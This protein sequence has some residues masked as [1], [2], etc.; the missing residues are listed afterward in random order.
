[1]L[2]EP[3][4][5]CVVTNERGLEINTGLQNSECADNYEWLVIMLRCCNNICLI[6]QKNLLGFVLNRF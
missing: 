4:A 2:C 3:V 6:K 5:P 1:M